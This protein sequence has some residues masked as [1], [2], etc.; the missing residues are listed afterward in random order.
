LVREKGLSERI[1]VIRREVIDFDRKILNGFEVKNP[2][3][4][5]LNID[6]IRYIDNEPMAIERLYFNNDRCGP[7]FEKAADSLIYDYLVQELKINFAYIDEYLEP[8]NLKSKE[9]RLLNVKTGSPALLITK[10][11]YN[12]RDLW[13]EYSNTTIR[14]DKCRYHVSLK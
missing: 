8:I 5:I 13:L 6:R 11:S 2:S 10:I 4:Q 12:P 14:G 1:E 9:A 7:M 3:R